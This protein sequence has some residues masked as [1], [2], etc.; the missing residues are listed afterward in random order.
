MRCTKQG[1]NKRKVKTW[2]KSK[3]INIRGSSGGNG[4]LGD[5]HIMDGRVSPDAKERARGE[6]REGV[7][8]ER[9]TDSV[10]GTSQ[11]PGKR[12][13]LSHILLYINV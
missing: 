3:N 5:R 6:H 12:S 7:G 11:V 13:I 1:K 4:Y 8:P 9:R 10:K 2:P